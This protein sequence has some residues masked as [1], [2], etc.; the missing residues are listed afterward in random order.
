MTSKS[1]INSY[2][3]F[4]HA[5]SGR[6]RSG[7]NFAHLF[8][9]KPEMSRQLDF[10]N[11]LSSAKV[12]ALGCG[13]GE[14]VELLRSKGIK[15]ENIIGID[16]SSKLIEIAKQNYPEID[17]RVGNMEDLSDFSSSSFDLVYSSLAMHY[18]E[19]WEKV[20]SEIS[21]VLKK[22][23]QFIFSTHHPIFWG[24]ENMNLEGK[25]FNIIGFS[26]E[27]D[28]R[29]KVEIFGNYLTKLKKEARWF[30]GKMRIE[31]FNRSLSEMFNSLTLAG[32]QIIDFAEPRVLDEAKEKDIKLWKVNHEIPMFCVWRVKKLEGVES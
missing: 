3:Q 7:K 24:S 27:K 26:K 8:I 25:S 19:S 15:D 17:F 6:M 23:G 5:Y 20:L 29:N 2:D 4:A 32:F 11:D 9:E 13:S 10:V 21:R 18:L 1:T 30:E 28:D 22:E 16:I 14:E 12:L 31:F